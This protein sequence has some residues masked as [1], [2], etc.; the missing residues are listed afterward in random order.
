MKYEY[1]CPYCWQMIDTL[2]DLSVLEQTYVEDCQVC[3]SPIEIHYQ[4]ADHEHDNQYVDTFHN[5]MSHSEHD[6]YRGDTLDDEIPDSEDLDDMND[7]DYIDH[8]DYVETTV[9]C[10]E[11]R[12]E[13][14][15]EWS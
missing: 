5:E 1:I 2:I 8:F 10:F 9:I 11:V 13:N 6:E 12:Q 7:M 3:C 14:G 15:G 4:L